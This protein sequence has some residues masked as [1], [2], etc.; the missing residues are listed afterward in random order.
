MRRALT[1]VIKAKKLP[2][3]KPFPKGHSIGVAT[4]F[5]P[6]VCPNPGGRPKSKEVN[7]ACREFLGSDIGKSPKVQTNAE[8]MVAKFGRKAMRGDLA[9]AIF[10]AERAEGRP[11]VQMSV[12]GSTD[13]LSL[14]VA[15]MEHR[16]AE[17]GPPEGF[18]PLQPAGEGEEEQA[19]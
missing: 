3:G 15:H 5:I 14:I 7:A 19:Q 1:P 2:R 9:A 18:I 16:S 4:R 11:A 6:G 8:S 12:D 10:L 17:L 13:H